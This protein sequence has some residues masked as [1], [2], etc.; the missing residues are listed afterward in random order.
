MNKSGVV[1]IGVMIA[2]IGGFLTYGI[3]SGGDRLQTE[4]EFIEGIHETMGS[5]PVD[6]SSGTISSSGS[7]PKIELETQMF[8][9]GFIENDR[10]AEREFTISNSGDAPLHINKIT[11][12]CGCTKGYAQDKVIAPGEEGVIRVTVDPSLVK[13][14]YS[15][16]ML[17]VHTDDP[18][19]PA[20]QFNV[21]AFV[22]SEID[23]TPEHL[24]FGL[25]P[26]GKPGELRVHIAQRENDAFDIYEANVDSKEFSVVF[27]ELPRETWADPDRREFEVLVTLSSDASP[28]FH[29]GKVMLTTNLKRTRSLF[30]PLYAKVHE[31]S[32]FFS[33]NSYIFSRA[34]P[35][36]HYADVVSLNAE[37]VITVTDVKGA[38]E[39]I[40]VSVSEKSTDTHVLFDLSTD[41]SIQEDSI[42]DQ[43]EISFEVGGESYT[44]PVS[45]TLRFPGL[46]KEHTD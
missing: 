6:L 3:F 25:V 33:P 44:T 2:V 1:I 34:E 13:G 20:A 12:S 29:S 24:D 5:V 16:K 42:T 21:I 36:G 38:R 27:T 11:T 37:E 31:D 10:I 43:W 41:P 45:L 35:G 30:L 26:S 7:M 40:K 23:I 19:R 22:D 9:L 8:R 28:G 32:F 15:A 4:D 39:D 17:T 14:F 18:N 46:D